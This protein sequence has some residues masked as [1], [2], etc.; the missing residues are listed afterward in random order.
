MGRA[1]MR[2][3]LTLKTLLSFSKEMGQSII[4]KGKEKKIVLEFAGN[5]STSTLGG[6]WH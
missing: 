2:F 3:V 4:L 5:C 1:W 6:I